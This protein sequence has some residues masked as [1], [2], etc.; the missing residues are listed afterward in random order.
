LDDIRFCIFL[1]VIDL[2]KLACAWAVRLIWHPQRDLNPC[3]RRESGFWAILR[4]LQC[5]AGM[6]INHCADEASR[7]FDRTASCINSA[8][9]TP[10]L[11]PTASPPILRKGSAHRG[12]N[13]PPSD[14][15]FRFHVSWRCLPS[16]VGQ[17]TEADAGVRS[18]TD[19]V[20]GV[21]STKRT[22]RFPSLP[23]GK[24]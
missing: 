20:Q 6:C 5:L 21:G 4:C 16:K 22:D 15:Q 1:Y 19:V 18:P 11:V 13:S 17:P 2:A 3:Y 7:H 12:E 23:F 14:A 8:Y 10:P 9:F 24:N